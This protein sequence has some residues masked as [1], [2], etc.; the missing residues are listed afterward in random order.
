[1]LCSE[2]E[3]R[4]S[5]LE[6]P[7]AATVFRPLMEDPR[8][9]VSYGP[10]ALPFL[11]SVL[12]R[13]L[14]LF[15]DGKEADLGHY[16][17]DAESVEVEWRNFLLEKRDLE[18]YG[19]VHLIVSDIAL[20]DSPQY[21]RYLTRDADA[22]LMW[23]D[24]S[25]LIGYYVKFAKLLVFAELAPADPALWVNTLV[26]PGGGMIRPGAVE[27]HDGSIGAF[28]IDRA[29]LFESCRRKGM[30]TI[31]PVQREKI[32]ARLEQNASKFALTELALALRR[33]SAWN[34]TI[35]KVER[36]EPCPCGSGRKYK[37]CHGA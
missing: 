18:S 6:T 5:K 34:A 30:A 15:L 29:I 31:S 33:D 20:P 13:N 19:R 32:K 22:T 2:C 27:V 9:S 14:A 37:R 21:N 36:N 8:S 3:I 24:R 12:W 35:P 28:L 4:F 16:R 7:F 25:G 1:M 10:W 11:I 26:D 17:Q 23:T